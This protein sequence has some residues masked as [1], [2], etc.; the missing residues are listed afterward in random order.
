MRNDDDAAVIASRPSAVDSG[1]GLPAAGSITLAR[2][3]QDPRAAVREHE[4]VCLLCGAAFRQLTNTHLL[5]HGLSSIEYKRRFGYNLG[6]PLMC[7]ALRGLYAERARDVGLA[8]RIRRRPL[9]LDPELR[10]RGGA[11]EIAVEETL[12]RRDVQRLPRRRWSE[13]DARGRFVSR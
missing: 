9:L 5:A 11:R 12:T 13:R 4:I 10:R 3:P 7:H 2:R 6:R 8:A 1:Q